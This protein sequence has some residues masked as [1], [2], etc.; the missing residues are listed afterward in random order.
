MCTAVGACTPWATHHCMMCALVLPVW[1]APTVRISTTATDLPAQDGVE[2]QPRVRD[3]RCTRPA[4][5]HA[6]HAAQHGRAP[7]P[8]WRAPRPCTGRPARHPRPP[9]PPRPRRASA[10]GTSAPAHG[11]TRVMSRCILHAPRPSWKHGKRMLMMIKGLHCKR[12]CCSW[13]QHVLA[14]P[15]GGA[16]GADGAEEVMAAS[17]VRER[18]MLRR[19]MAR[20]TAR[21]MRACVCLCAAFVLARA[22]SWASQD[23]DRGAAIDAIACH[24]SR[25]ETRAAAGHALTIANSRDASAPSAPRH[26]RT[27]RIP[28]STSLA[29]ALLA[30]AALLVRA[31]PQRNSPKAQH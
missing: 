26:S 18:L 17:G 12:A 31:L 9:R 7:H 10:S 22:S 30:A 6:R 23:R 13:P 27:M 29:A 14:R 24:G 2:G 8:W 20:C 25:R 11:A 5:P 21:S 16:A 1:P 28:R 4:A 19:W 15:A 3:V